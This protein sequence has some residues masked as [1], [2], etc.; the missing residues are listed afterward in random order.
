MNMFAREVHMEHKPQGVDLIIA[1]DDKLNDI[2]AWTMDPKKKRDRLRGLFIDTCD[3]VTGLKVPISN[4]NVQLK[5][6]TG[7]RAIGH[8]CFDIATEAGVDIFA[9]YKLPPEVLDTLFADLRALMGYKCIKRLTFSV[10]N[11]IELLCG[12]L[13]KDGTLTK[14]ACELMPHTSFLPVGLVTDLK[15]DY[16]LKRLGFANRAEAMKSFEEDTLHFDTNIS[17]VICGPKDIPL[18][19]KDFWVCLNA[20]T[21]AVRPTGLPGNE[22]NNLNAFDVPKAIQ[23]GSSGLVIGSPVMDAKMGC[24]KATELVIGQIGEAQAA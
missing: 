22:A 19:E 24:R 20:V 21:P 13:E 10:K 23:I 6:N 8:E 15:D 3:A 11:Q 4:A 17:E 2:A 7:L 14:G 5:S 1:V 18:F 12:R 16:Y 9:D